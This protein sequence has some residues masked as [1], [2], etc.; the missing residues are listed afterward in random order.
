MHA[1]HAS[2]L[3]PPRLPSVSAEP[4]LGLGGDA[5]PARPACQMGT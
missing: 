2:L 1:A 5:V 3:R 4:A